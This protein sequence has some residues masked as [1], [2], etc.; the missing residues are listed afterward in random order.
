MPQSNFICDECD[1]TFR[2]ERELQDHKMLFHSPDLNDD[3]DIEEGR[4][5]QGRE[6][7]RAQN[8]AGRRI[9]ASRPRLRK[10]GSS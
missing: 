2:T 1:D 9:A 4:P 10:A 7:S 5:R 8:P 6:A 3:D